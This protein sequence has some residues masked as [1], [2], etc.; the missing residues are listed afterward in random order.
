[1]QD[2]LILNDNEFATSGDVTS[3]DSAEYSIMVWDFKSTARLSNQIF[4]VSNFL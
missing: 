3:K 4:H 2:I 1:V